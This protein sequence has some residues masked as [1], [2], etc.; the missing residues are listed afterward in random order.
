MVFTGNVPLF[1]TTTWL[2]NIKKNRDISVFRKVEA[3]HF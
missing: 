2:K 1:L 3:F